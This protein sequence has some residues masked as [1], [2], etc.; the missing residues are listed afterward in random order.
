MQNYIPKPG[1]R[2]EVASRLVEKCDRL[3][4]VGCGDGVIQHFLGNRVGRIYGVD[5][6]KEMLKIAAKRGLNVKLV[7]LDVKRLPFNSNFFDVVTCLDVIEHVRDPKALLVKM[8]RVLK[9]GGNLI[10]A[11]PNIRFSNHLYELI[12]KG[13][14]PKTSTDT[15]LYDG[16]HLHFFTY[17]DLVKLLESVGFFIKII[18]G[19]INKPRRG[20][21]GRILE[22][23]LGKKIML[24]FRAPGILIVGKKTK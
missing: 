5:S 14:F 17:T 13:R 23:I 12:I 2:V 4:D 8:N 11:T 24:E 18:E 19:I 16:G 6:S 10:I 9:R 22:F 7:D 3:L 20:L 21:K 1:E 15:S